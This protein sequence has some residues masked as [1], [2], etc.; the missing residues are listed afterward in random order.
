MS[1]VGNDIE[2]EKNGFFIAYFDALSVTLFSLSHTWKRKFKRVLTLPTYKFK[3]HFSSGFFPFY[4]WIFL[5]LAF[6][7]I[8]NR[9]FFKTLLNVKW[10]LYWGYLLFCC[11]L[12]YLCILQPIVNL[13]LLISSWKNFFYDLYTRKIFF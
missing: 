1:L 10:I 4:C 3:E 13:A 8:F 2:Q 12:I 5:L 6:R 9:R 7:Q 11:Y